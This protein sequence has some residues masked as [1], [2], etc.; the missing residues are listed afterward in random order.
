MVLPRSQGDLYHRYRPARFN[1]VVGHKE[2][3]SSIQK[4]LLSDNPSQAYMLVGESGCGKTTTARIMA[5]LLNCE[6]VT[7]GEPCLECNPCKMILAGKCVDVTEM[8]AADTRGIDDA[9]TLRNSMSLMPM[10]VSKKVYIL[11]EAQGFTGDAQETLLKVLEE[12]PS[13]VYIVLCTTDPKKIKKT[14]RN[15]CQNFTFR[16]LP[17]NQLMKLLLD[18]STLETFDVSNSVLEKIAEQS[19]GSPRNSLVLLQQVSQVGFENSNEVEKLLCAEE[20]DNSDVFELCKALQYSGSPSKWKLVSDL[21]KKALNSGETPTGIGM[22]LAGYF[23][24]KL[25]NASD[26]KDV[27]RFSGILELFEEPLP[28]LKLGENKLVLRL[29]KATELR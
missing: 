28:D 17:K 23:R 4:A 7:E 12:A 11:D 25:L 6:S 20:V 27:K 1:E 8:N 21:Y 24:N 2:V 15:R 9:R 22:M 5:L 29:F 16:P 26:Y 19:G 13:H 3:I 14:V 18:V 10:Q